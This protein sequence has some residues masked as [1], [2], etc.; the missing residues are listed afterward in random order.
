MIAAEFQAVV[1]AA[2]RGNR[3]PEL[4]EGRPKCLLPVGPYPLIWYSLMMLQRHGFQEVIVIVLEHEKLEIQ[5]KLEKT[6]IKLRIDFHT[7]SGDSDIGTA[8]ALR[9]ISDRIKTD[10]V[11]VS[12]DIIVEYSLYPVLQQFR[13]QNASI[14]G[15]MLPSSHPSVVVPGPKTKHKSDKD[16][17]GTCPDSTRLVF[18]GSAS[19]FETDFKIS[20]HLLRFYGAV[21]IR[22]D[23]MDTHVY[24]IKKWIVDFLDVVSGFS[25]LKGELLPFIVKKQNSSV[26]NPLQL[27][28]K[29]LSEINVNTNKDVF[30]FTSHTAL[31][32]KINKSSI[33]TTQGSSMVNDII[34]CYLAIAPEETYG[35][36][37]NSLPS[38]CLANRQ[39]YEVF[40][41]VS[42]FPITAVKAQNSDIKS[43]QVT[44]TVVGEQTIIS[45][46]T[47]IT[48]STIGSNCIVKQKVLISNST[49]MDHVT[50]EEGVTID[51]CIICDKS[52]ISSGSTLRNCL[53]GS[54]FLVSSNT[55]KE[56]VHLSNSDGFM[57]I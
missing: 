27:M 31:D 21:D 20:G 46:K 48:S 29:P 54:N 57:E 39:I 37:V 45:E 15:L 2:G 33:F 34:Q 13:E 50:I 41:K 6:Q 30:Q 53:I 3:F 49:I 19:D 44:S 5:Q 43:T 32:E 7:I 10:V 51:N 14:V 47:S 36:R 17:F 8:D 38:F 28:E 12:C 16:L 18:M 25:T 11:L 1:F 4:V 35:I 42:D 24:V 40:S 26:I 52:M 22:S 55:K 23:L 56:N 9:Q